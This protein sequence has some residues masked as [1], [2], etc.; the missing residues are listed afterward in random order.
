MAGDLTF[1]DLRDRTGLLQASVSPEFTDGEGVS[2]A[3]ELGAE[4]V[5]QVRGEVVLRPEPNPELATGEVELQVH[6]MMRL[7]PA[8]TPPRRSFDS[9]I[10]PWTSAARSSSTSLP[11]GTVWSWRPARRWTVWASWRS[12]RPS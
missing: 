8:E 10:V 5:V 12:R 9:S 2:L 1:L 6:G 4:D 11:F 7:N 3:R